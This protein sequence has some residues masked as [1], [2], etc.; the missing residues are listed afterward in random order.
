MMK[1]RITHTHTCARAHTHTHNF[2]FFN[3]K[4]F[5]KF[6]RFKIGKDHLNER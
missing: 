2:L 5:D 4:Y 6:D 3:T 1:I